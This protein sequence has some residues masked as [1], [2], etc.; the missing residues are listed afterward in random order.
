[1]CNM[2]NGTRCGTV[3]GSL[4]QPLT[5]RAD[6]GR[7]SA[8]PVRPEHRHVATTRDERRDASTG[9]KE[10][11]VW[12][13]SAE[14]PANRIPPQSTVPDLRRRCDAQL[15]AA[16]A[17]VA[18]SCLAGSFPVPPTNSLSDPELPIGPPVPT[19]ASE[20]ASEVVRVPGGR[21]MSTLRAGRR[22]HGRLA[23]WRAGAVHWCA[24]A[25]S[26][27]R[28]AGWRTC[29]ASTGSPS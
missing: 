21:P 4:R 17:C 6:Q 16:L 29:R 24:T 12:A 22:G 20:G 25:A 27:I 26:K 1:M 28:R 10:V 7:D 13:T 2:L 18:P 8:A 9:R 14:G 11:Q 23:I 15:I 19:G 3:G 5:A